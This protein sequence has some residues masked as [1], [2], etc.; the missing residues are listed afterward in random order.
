MNKKEAHAK[1]TELLSAGEKKQNVF[2]ALSGQGV[3]DRVLAWCI[4]SHVDAHRIAQN[5]GHRLAILAIAYL[6]LMIAIG[7]SLYFMSLV[8][9]A[10]LISALFTVPLCVLFIWGF[11]KNKANVYSAFI[12][13]S[14]S[15]IPRQLSRFAD[16]PLFTTFA[17]VLSAAIIWYASFVLQR[18][19]PD[20]GFVFVRKTQGRYVFTD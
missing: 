18:L 16:D 20:F 11:T 6:H 9:V 14:L 13:L 17:L 3:K 1:I 7:V 5:R 8:P 19:F 2:N 10:G 15:Q 12:L 4:A